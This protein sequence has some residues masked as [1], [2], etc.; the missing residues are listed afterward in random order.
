MAKTTKKVKINKEFVQ[1]FLEEQNG[2]PEVGHFEDSADL[3]KFYKHCTDEQ[4]DE[5]L[6]VEGITDEVKHTDSE[7]ILRMRKC[8]AI[9]YKHF[10]KAPSASKKKASPYA[11]YTLED[12]MDMVVEYDAEIE[13]CDDERI[14]RMRAIMALKKTEAFNDVEEA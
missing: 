13:P 5:W 12:L 10:P 8:M 1:N 9:L 11:K 2:Y 6:D 7:Q 3:K 4:L 14:L